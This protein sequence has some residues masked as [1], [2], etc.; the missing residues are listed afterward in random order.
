MRIF[1]FLTFFLSITLAA[2]NDNTPKTYTSITGNWRCTEFSSLNGSRSYLVEIDR[3]KSDTTLYA[4]TYF[5][6]TTYNDFIFVH[7]SGKNISISQQQV[8][9]TPKI[10]RT[11]SGQVSSDFK[12]IDWNYTLYD[13]VSE[14]AVQ[15]VYTR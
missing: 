10:V 3:T 1:L 11:G 8:G 12:R 9:T 6:N 2:C 7:L 13:G 15:A 4:I 5:A 14:Y